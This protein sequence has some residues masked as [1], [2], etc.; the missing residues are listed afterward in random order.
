MKDRTPAPVLHISDQSTFGHKCGAKHYSRSADSSKRMAGEGQI[1]FPANSRPWS[2]DCH[3]E[4]GILRLMSISLPALL[5]V[6]IVVRNEA[7]RLVDMVTGVSKHLASLATDHE[8]I[9][10]DNGSQD[11]SIQHLRDMTGSGGLPNVQVY[12]LTKEVDFDTAAWAGVENALGD[13][14]AVFD[15]VREDPGYLATMIAAATAG[16]DVVF[17]ENQDRSGTTFFYRSASHVF[18]RLYRWFNGVDPS[19]DAPRFRLLSRRIVNVVMQYPAPSLSYRLLPAT[20][21]FRK[22]NLSYRSAPLARSKSHFF[23]DFDR[24]MRLFVSSNRA[25]MRVVT[26]L[27]MFGAA[28]NVV[29]T[30]Y[31]VAIAILKKDVAPGWITL[32][33]QQSGMFFLI[34]L[35]LLVLAE[36]ILHMAALS[37]EGPRYFVG[38]EFNSA[39]QT[40]RQK[41]NVEESTVVSLSSRAAATGSVA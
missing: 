4:S 37:S 12:C 22:V 20:G 27:S 13:Y 7:V 24:A 31:V 41:L 25:P 21:G 10:V 2:S 39:I 3:S 33:L 28:A 29:Y 23:D 11:G 38:Q 1:G 40:R 19:H 8:L 5:S 17:A 15:P 35:V 14:V 32:S 36:Y 18:H 9:V 34:S 16:A 6:V 26:S 30:G